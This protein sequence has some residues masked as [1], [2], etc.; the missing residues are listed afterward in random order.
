MAK[1]STNQYNVFLET[2]L[3]WTFNFADK[4]NNKIH[5]NLYPTNI[6]ESTLSAVGLG[7]VTCWMFP[8]YALL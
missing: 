7:A 6:D 1:D 8:V 4:L 5:E 2:V 3:Q